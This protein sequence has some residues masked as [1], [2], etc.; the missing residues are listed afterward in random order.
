MVGWVEGRDDGC[1]DGF[2]EGLALDCHEGRD[3]GCAA[4]CLEG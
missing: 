2:A 4:G 1:V 3:V